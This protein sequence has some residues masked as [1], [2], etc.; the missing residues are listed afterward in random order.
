MLNLHEITLEISEQIK[1]YVKD[2]V[3]ESAASSRTKYLFDFV[4]C[5]FVRSFFMFLF[6]TC[7]ES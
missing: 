1:R 7:E 3:K 5:G 6:Q 2:R 4:F